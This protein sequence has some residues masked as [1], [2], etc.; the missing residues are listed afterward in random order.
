[1][2]ILPR[3]LV[4]LGLAFLSALLCTMPGAAQ[5]LSYQG[6]A[7]VSSPQIVVVYWGPNVDPT[8]QSN[9]PGMYNTLLSGPWMN[10]LKQYSTVGLTPLQGGPSSGQTMQA[11]AFGKAVTITP[12]NPTAGTEGAIVQELSNQIVSGAVPAPTLDPQG[13]SQ[14]IYVVYFPPGF[15]FTDYSQPTRTSCKDFDEIEFNLSYQATKVPTILFSDLSGAP[16]RD[17]AV[18]LMDQYALDNSVQLAQT[19]TGPFIPVPNAPASPLAASGWD[20]Y[21][22]PVSGNVI[23]KCYGNPAYFPFPSVQGVISPL[24]WSNAQRDVSCQIPAM[25]LQMISLF[26]RI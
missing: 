15:T 1:M 13:F 2:R 12:S 5:N 18:P 8:L 9:L 16:C 26:P 7:V 19:I 22:G 10:I 20:D 6:G 3:L 23:G 24:L 17:T 4:R 14:T 25:P 11:G 21:V